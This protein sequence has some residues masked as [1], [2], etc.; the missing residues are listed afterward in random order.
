MTSLADGSGDFHLI[1]G[2]A[3]RRDGAIFWRENIETTDEASQM[4]HLRIESTRTIFAE[5]HQVA[6]R[7]FSQHRLFGRLW[8]NLKKKFRFAKRAFNRVSNLHRLFVHRTRLFVF[9]TWQYPTFQQVFVETV[10]QSTK[11]SMFYSNRPF[12][13]HSEYSSNDR[14][15][16]TPFAIVLIDVVVVHVV[17]WRIADNLADLLD[18]STTMNESRRTSSSFN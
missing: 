15:T 2:R 5:I 7:C 6:A 12:I 17:L 9:S 1:S 10:S 14:L 8:S 11:R 4:A 3:V 18:L 16:L 13:R